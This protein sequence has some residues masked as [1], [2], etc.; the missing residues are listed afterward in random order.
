MDSAERQR[1]L[2]S[3]ESDNKKQRNDLNTVCMIDINYFTTKNAV[4]VPPIRDMSE[5]LL[6]TVGNVVPSSVI[7][8]QLD[9]WRNTKL[10]CIKF[11]EINESIIL[12]C[13]EHSRTNMQ[14]LRTAIGKYIDEGWIV[15]SIEKIPIFFENYGRIFVSPIISLS[16]D[17][18][19]VKEIFEGIIANFSEFR[20]LHYFGP[21][22][23]LP[24]LCKETEFCDR[25]LKLQKDGNPFIVKQSDINDVYMRRML[26]GNNSQ[27]DLSGHDFSFNELAK[28]HR[29][30][31]VKHYWRNEEHDAP[32][33]TGDDIDEDIRFHSEFNKS[34]SPE[35]Q[36][37]ASN[38]SK[39]K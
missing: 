28:K 26:L 8:Q 29:V 36:P 11:S 10:E 39:K 3:V 21:S 30:E 27:I 31:Y 22:L 9:L 6:R 4:I 38:K 15:P 17:H 37:S 34:M 12:K 32:M 25:V 35:E 18:E 5:Y 1:N 2:N 14:D 13:M 16:S 20:S 24:V 19:N 33:F 23:T 7:K